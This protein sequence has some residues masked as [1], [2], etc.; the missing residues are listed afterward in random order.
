MNAQSLVNESIH[1]TLLKLI[2][3]NPDLSQRDLAR[4]M[5]VSLGKANYCL[6]ALVGKGFVKLENFRRSDNKRA[7]MYHLTPLGLEE[8]ARLTLCFLRIKEAEYETIKE[9]ISRLRREVE[10][11]SQSAENACVS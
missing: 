5:G 10:E 2:E 6:R 8:K 3:A 4:T 1:Y 9:E 11:S 7:Y